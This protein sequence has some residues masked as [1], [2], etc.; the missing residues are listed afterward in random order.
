VRLNERQGELTHPRAR[1]CDAPYFPCR[2]ESSES[3]WGL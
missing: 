1:L 3:E 2:E